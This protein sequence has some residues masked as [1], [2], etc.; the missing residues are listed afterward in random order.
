LKLTKNNFYLSSTRH[1]ESIM[2][3]KAKEVSEVEAA[4]E[5][6]PRLAKRVLGIT[7]DAAITVLVEANPK[8]ESSAS[9]QRFEGYLTDPRPATVQAALDNG[10]TMGDIK[11]DTIH[12]FISVEGAEVEEYEVNPRG[13]RVSAEDA[14]DVAVAAEA[15]QEN[16]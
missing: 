7:K 4:A 16:F 12:G 14:E 15:E 11:F 1:K 3:K 2:A 9:Y 13:P 10:L 8:R 5:T 6:G